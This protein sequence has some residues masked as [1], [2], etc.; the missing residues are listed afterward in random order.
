MK[1]N[2]ILED[3]ICLCKGTN[4]PLKDEC[5]RYREEFK[6]L[7][8]YFTIPPYKNGGCEAFRKIMK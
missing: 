5:I 1:E 6:D 4:C 7:Q 2:F 3:D 8:T